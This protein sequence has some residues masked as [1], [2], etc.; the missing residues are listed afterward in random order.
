MAADRSGAA[1]REGER[2]RRDDRRGDAGHDGRPGLRG[3]AA[4]GPQTV[5][6][7]DPAA[8]FADQQAPVP[9][10]ELAQAEAGA[11]E[12]ERQGEDAHR[13][14]RGARQP[15]PPG[16]GAAERQRARQDARDGDDPRDPQERGVPEQ[17]GE[18]QPRQHRQH[19]EGQDRERLQPPRARGG[20]GLRGTRAAPPRGV[21]DGRA[22]AALRRLRGFEQLGRAAGD[23]EQ[24]RDPRQR[25]R[26]DTQVGAGRLPLGLG[27]GAH[28]DQA[29][30]VA[31]SPVGPGRGARPRAAPGGHGA[32]ASRP[33][34]GRSAKDG[35][36]RA[37][38]PGS[39]PGGRGAR[40]ARPPPGTALSSASAELGLPA[41][42]SIST[43]ASSSG[44]SACSISTPERATVGQWIL[45]AGLPGRWTRSESSDW[46][47]LG[48]GAS[49]AVQERQRGGV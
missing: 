30:P 19:L 26:R 3:A 25:L 40:T 33:A 41:W 12:R 18:A 8:Q 44:R 23:R 4:V 10:R 49:G 5:Q 22:H 46:G 38:A 35:C 34:Q 21:G 42:S 27:A 48:R 2:G 9:G 47:R 45:E 13:R 1:A 6:R 20:A 39:R 43:R 15:A 36:P 14:R 24:R 31:H 37:A 17:R 7:F 16:G 28:P 11:P 29:Q 32:P